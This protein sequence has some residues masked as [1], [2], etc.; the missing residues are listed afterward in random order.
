LVPCLEIV[1]RPTPDQEARFDFL[2]LGHMDTVFPKGT[3]GRRPFSIREGRAYGPGVCDMKG[4]LVTALHVAEVVEQA[5]LAA[6]LSICIAFNSDEEVG[7]KA[8]Q[9]WL[10]GLAAMSRRVFVLEPCRPA[11]QRVLERKGVGFFEVI[12]HGRSAHAGVE[13]ER[14]VNAILELSHQVIK[15]AGFNQ[16]EDGTTVNVTTMAG[17]TAKNVIPDYA[18]AG[19]DVRFSKMEEMHRIR[20]AFREMSPS[21]YIEGVRVQ[22]NGDVNRPPMVPSEA[23]FKLWE[24]V[25]ALGERMGLSMHLVSSGGGSDGNFTAALGI[26]TIDAMGPQGGHAHSDEEYLHLDSVIPNIRLI[27]EVMK[28]AAM[29]ELP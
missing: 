25:S 27:V 8:S 23:T 13:P 6:Q 17:G 4:G 11:G 21:G 20:T 10:E 12:C 5:G 29:G 19:F 1:N 14:G 3:A 16:P 15:A 24:A 2:F 7:S 18:Q 9:Q 28:A 26:P 22:V